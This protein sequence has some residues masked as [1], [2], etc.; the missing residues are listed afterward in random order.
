MTR[1][2]SMTPGEVRKSD[3]ISSLVRD[4]LLECR[5]EIAHEDPERAV[6]TGLLFAYSAIHMKVF[7]PRS[8]LALSSDLGPLGLAD[9]LTLAFLRYAIVAPTGARLPDY[10]R[11]KP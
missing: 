3:R 4:W 6:T 1:P 11:Y 2:D 9:E 8:R 5:D 7:F 10:L